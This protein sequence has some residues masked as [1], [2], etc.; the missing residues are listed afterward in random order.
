[1]FAYDLPAWFLILSLFLP[2]IALFAE[3]TQHCPMP[4]N[5][6]WSFLSWAFI[7]RVLVLIMIY[8]VLGFSPWFYI[9]LGVLALAYFGGIFRGFTRVLST[10]AK[11]AAKTAAEDTP[12]KALR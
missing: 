4:F 11:I 10:I 12:R 1:M 7:P 3:W 5:Q 6:P 8:T 2:R 9:H